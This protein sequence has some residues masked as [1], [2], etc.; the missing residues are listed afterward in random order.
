MAGLRRASVSGRLSELPDGGAA[1]WGLGAR[2]G[3]ARYTLQRRHRALWH[4]LSGGHVFSAGKVWLTP[5]FGL[6]HTMIFICDRACC[7]TWNNWKD[8]YL[9][10]D[11]AFMYVFEMHTGCVY[12]NKRKCWCKSPLFGVVRLHTCTSWCMY[13]CVVKF[14]LCTIEVVIRRTVMCFLEVVFQTIFNSKSNMSKD[15]EYQEFRL[16]FVQSLNSV[17]VKRFRRK[18]YLK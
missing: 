5:R 10:H 18:C 3:A 13:F 4:L 2:R 14:N 8:F 11:L 9:Y 7:A 12:K 6:A 16:S 1:V 15:Y 17:N